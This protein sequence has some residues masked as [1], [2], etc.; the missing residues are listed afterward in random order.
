MKKFIYTLIAL[1]FLQISSLAA[2]IKVE[3]LSDFS[4]ENPAKSLTVKAVTSLEL[5]DISIQPNYILTGNI[6][7]VKPPKR[8][9][10]D[11]RF[12]FELTHYADESGNF[13]SVKK[14]IKGKY[15][16]KFDYKHAAK[17]AALGVGSYFVTGLSSGYYAVEGAV[18][19]E[20]DNRLK[21]SVVSVY[22]N[23]PLSY[24][25]KGEHLNISK[26]QIFI[27]KFKLKDEEDTDDDYD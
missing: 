24:V 6:V 17:S 21:S 1:M 10:R 19:N 2:T 12:S 3:S 23:S 14:G 13:Y 11:A 27:L 5:D 4:T 7:D 15:T 18:K 22:E 26:N 9:K 8:L 25:E 16:N 20:E